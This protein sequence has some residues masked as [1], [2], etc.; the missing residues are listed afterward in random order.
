MNEWSRLIVDVLE[1]F[2]SEFE[3]LEGIAHVEVVGALHPFFDT[4]E[5]GRVDVFH[6]VEEAEE[7]LDGRNVIDY[8]ELRHLDKGG[9]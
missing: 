7:F 4:R 3:H 5:E 2:E 8:L 9:L 1:G 6:L